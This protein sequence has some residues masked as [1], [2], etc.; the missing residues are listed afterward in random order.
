MYYLYW[1]VTLLCLCIIYGIFT[2]DPDYESSSYDS[3]SSTSSK[4]TSYNNTNKYELYNSTAVTNLASHRGRYSHSKQIMQLVEATYLYFPVKVAY[5]S[6]TLTY[7]KKDCVYSIK[8]N[9]FTAL[10]SA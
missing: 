2:W 6:D 4:S 8:P 7:S 1:Q 5:T 9:F 10:F 3:R